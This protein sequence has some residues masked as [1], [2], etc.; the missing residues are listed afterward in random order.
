MF[1]LLFTYFD[2]VV[3]FLKRHTVMTNLLCIN[4]LQFHKALKVTLKR[5]FKVFSCKTTKK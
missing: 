2:S 4:A 1:Y 5:L 3:I